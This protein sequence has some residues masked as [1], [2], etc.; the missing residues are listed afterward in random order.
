MATIQQ[1]RQRWLQA[2]ILA[3]IIVVV[4][5]IVLFIANAYAQKCPLQFPKWAVAS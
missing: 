5:T 2:M 1:T 4:S 3:T